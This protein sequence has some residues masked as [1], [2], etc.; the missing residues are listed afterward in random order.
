MSS[1]NRFS[2]RF[3]PSPIQS[4]RHS[5]PRPSTQPNAGAPPQLELLEQRL[6]LSVSALLDG[7][8][9]TILSDEADAIVV[10]NDAGSVAV[11]GTAVDVG[12]PISSA[13][14]T[15]L[16][17]RGGPGANSID[18]SGVAKAAFTS[19]AS[20][21]VDGGDG[22]DTIVG[23]P[24][25]DVLLGGAGDDSIDGGDGDDII[26]G[27]L[28]DDQLTGGL[29][30]DAVMG[31]AGADV[32]D[33]EIGKVND[34]SNLGADLEAYLQSVQDSLDGVF[35]RP[36][37][38]VGDQLAGGISVANGFIADPTTMGQ[39]LAGDDGFAADVGTALSSLEPAPPGLPISAGDV[40][41]ALFDAL[42]AAG[43]G[44]LGDTDASGAVNIND[45]RFVSQADGDVLFDML[46]ERDLADN[47]SA[48]EAA[49]ML[50]VTFARF[51]GQ[52]VP[53][54]PIQWRL[55][56]WLDDGK[57]KDVDLGLGYRYALAFGV[58]ED[59]F[60][61]RPE[62]A[63]ELTVHLQAA[64]PN[65]QDRAT[66]QAGRLQVTA[67]DFPGAGLDAGPSG[68]TGTYTM[69]VLPDAALAARLNGSAEVNLLLDGKFHDDDS[70]P[71]NLRALAD[72]HMD[73]QF[74]NADPA[75]EQTLFGEVPTIT[76]DNVQLDLDSFF[77]GFVSE[78]VTQVQ[79]VTKP[80]Q[81][82]IDVLDTD[83]PVISDLGGPASLAE[84]IGGQQLGR[85]V[86]LV[87]FINSIHVP[88]S[89][90]LAGL[91]VDMG[92]F[93][94]S[95]PRGGSPVIL[96]YTGNPDA[97]DDAQSEYEAIFDPD[98][99]IGIGKG[100]F[101]AEVNPDA[102]DGMSLPLLT[103]PAQTFNLFAGQDAVL[104]LYD[105]PVISAGVQYE[106]FFSIF[107]PL[108]TTIGGS[109][110]VTV[111]LKF[112]YDTF[113]LAKYQATGNWYDILDGFYVFDREV[114]GGTTLP[115]EQDPNDPAEFTISAELGATLELNLAGFVRAGVWGGVF[116][117]VEFNLN[118]LPD[119]GGVYDGRVRFSELALNAQRGPEA[120]FD[121]SGALSAGLKFFVKVQIEIDLGFFSFTIT[122]FDYSKDLV[123]VTLLDFNYAS[124][125]VPPPAVA[126]QDAATGDLTL[127]ADVGGSF[128]NDDI[129]FL[130]PIHDDALG[131]GV[132][133]SARGATED[134]FNVGAILG[135]A[136][137]GADLIV[138]LPGVKFDAVIRG[139]AEDDQLVYLGDGRAELF[140]DAG[141]DTLK[142]RKGGDV[143]D[144]G[145]G[146]DTLSGGD[147]ADQLF[148][149]P[150]GDTLRGEAGDDLLDGG[151]GDDV[152]EGGRGDDDIQGGDGLDE[153][154][155]TIGDGSDT[156]DGGGNL[157]DEDDLL[158]IHGG[159]GDD[160]IN[161]LGAAGA[162][163]IELPGPASL[164][165]A[166][167][168]ALHFLL[169]A[170]ADSLTL[171]DLSA[172]GIREVQADMGDLGAADGAADRIYISASDLDDVLRVE[173]SLSA[174]GDGLEQD[175]DPD[176]VLGDA[177]DVDVEPPAADF[178]MVLDVQGLAYSLTVAGQSTPL[179]ALAVMGSEGDDEFRIGENVAAIAGVMIDGQGG[180]DTLVALDEPN[181]FR[182]V[183]ANAGHLNGL[184]GT[185][186]E[187]IENLVGGSAG[188]RFVFDDGASLDG[189]ID[190][191]EG[192]DT[193]DYAAF[194]TDVEVHLL[195]GLAAGVNGG[196]PGGV[197][198]IENAIGGQGDDSL[199]GDD[200]DN[201]LIGNAGQD[202]L[203]GAG[204]IDTVDYADAPGSVR[205]ILGGHNPPG[206]G[207]APADGWGSRDRLRSIENVIGSAQ[208]DFILGSVGPNVLDGGAGNDVIMGLPGDD[209]LI[210]G[211]GDDIL[212]GG[213]GSDVLDTSLGNDTVRGPADEV[214]IDLVNAAAMDLQPIAKSRGRSG[215]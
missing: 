27:G 113:G 14:V 20:V 159:R 189:T 76:F 64:I 175:T 35:A 81:P 182:I 91:F 125:A 2:H 32:E 104:F 200:N 85:L 194:T 196:R 151:S 62:A 141:N 100:P 136:G 87:D 144:G 192:A 37:P 95:D 25:G 41:T 118:D 128:S 5:S 88:E 202:W 80:L 66:F 186:F 122:L 103:D 165:V 23:S 211:P 48:G 180:S 205:V 69:D 15:S 86:D 176:D 78:I 71:I 147:A 54:D 57:V 149:G 53:D 70:L 215:K 79:K 160:V 30:A 93:T 68:F 43:L 129:F 11:N 26:S 59:G 163:A 45:V 82:L 46:L 198:G 72:F 212:H 67:S 89:G 12:G 209:L 154:L 63:D 6:L 145:E 201:V 84:L 181:V 155:W 39:F 120:I 108:G 152:I 50:G 143:L 75:A 109:L 10:T 156:I 97:L 135:N 8:T 210:G 40:R 133:V 105:L 107:G 7:Q 188:D 167:V 112:G 83:L 190:G 36:L 164:T 61:E 90:D 121:V 131:D 134:F 94:L 137:A 9:L 60:Y 191:K 33:G 213:P 1:N 197:T 47:T 146:D 73:W 208:D 4:R 174:T 172:S 207:N 150:G 124:P 126:F 184:D 28:G 51:T 169:G 185:R 17:V 183:S 106:Q 166:G 55:M 168:E 77:G 148:G 130:S 123:N 16:I 31:G 179:D 52:G 138:V 96:D 38:L 13:A 29:G 102:E 74:V 177:G 92:F 44:M 58:S 3:G 161:V 56:D 111:D 203:D 157:A 49:F 65:L 162:A 19:L 214:L 171:S 142:T 187:S 158:T 24:F 178:S 101:F 99:T 42:G 34:F 173:T 139:G 127:N 132:R 18:L 199:T 153:I 110:G 22:A 114:V 116:G 195:T 170:G 140:G 119:G 193:L 204:G 115:D 206:A 98:I 117:D 21:L